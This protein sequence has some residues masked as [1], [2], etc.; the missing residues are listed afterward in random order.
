MPAA[1]G[2]TSVYQRNATTDVWVSAILDEAAAR[3]AIAEDERAA[4]QAAR[5]SVV[6]ARVQAESNEG[7]LQLS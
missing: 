5:H 1:H 3:Q 7:N 4:Y 6:E 2:Q